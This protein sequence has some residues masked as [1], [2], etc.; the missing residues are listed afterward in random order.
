MFLLKMLQTD[1]IRT[2]TRLKTL[3]GVYQSQNLEDFDD[4]KLRPSVLP[5]VPASDVSSANTDKSRSYMVEDDPQAPAKG[6]GK[7]GYEA[8]KQPPASRDGSKRL[9]QDG[10][11]DKEYKLHDAYQLLRQRTWM[12][13]N[14]PESSVTAYRISAGIL[15]LILIS[16]VTFCL[17]TMP[18]LKTDNSK[19]WFAVI[20]IICVVIFTIE[21]CLK[22]WAAP[23]TKAFVIEPMN[24]IDLV[25][26]MPFYLQVLASSALNNTRI[27]RIVRLVRVFRILKLGGRFGKI[28]VVATAMFESLDMLGMLMFLLSLSVIIFSTLIYFTERGESVTVGDFSFYSRETD[29]SCGKVLT[30]D[31]QGNP[32]MV[33][34]CV[35]IESPFESIPDSFWWCMVTLMTVGYGDVY[36]TTDGGKVVASLAM[37]ASVLLLALPISVIGTEFTQQWAEYKSK[38]DANTGRKSTPQYAELRE[39]VQD[40]LLML[41]SLVHKISQAENDIDDAAVRLSDIVR[42]MKKE[43]KNSTRHTRLSIMPKNNGKDELLGGERSRRTSRS[44][45]DRKKRE[46][47]DLEELASDLEEKRWNHHDL[48]DVARTLDSE[49]FRA[50]LN[51]SVL[52]YRSL[53][54]YREDTSSLAAEHEELEEHVAGFGQALGIEAPVAE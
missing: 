2:D 34:E 30:N 24:L 40:H 4:P 20:E 18:S 52:H 33:E 13:M 9:M 11:N 54:K 1:A 16:S 43:R 6:K 22:L 26:I 41:D 47:E 12:L 39:A 50:S 14:D 49:Q 42:R 3:E 53:Q 29:I 10:E 46:L 51:Q 7:A 25:A 31:E 15:V 21:Y 44:G 27:L 28:Q 36:P 37:V 17:E 19:L 45:E 23:D 35:R 5:P 38:G 8:P 48:L 32:T